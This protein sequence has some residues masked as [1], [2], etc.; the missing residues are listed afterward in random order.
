MGRGFPYNSQDSSLAI[1]GNPGFTA[2]DIPA[3]ANLPTAKWWGAEGPEIVAVKRGRLLVQPGGPGDPMQVL[4][5]S[6]QEA[7]P[8]GGGR[9]T[10]GA[11]SVSPREDGSFMV[12][13]MMRERLEVFDPATKES[14]PQFVFRYGT[15]A[16]FENLN[17][18][19]FCNDE[20]FALDANKR[21]VHVDLATGDRSLVHEFEDA[22]LLEFIAAD[23]DGRLVVVDHEF[24][25][26][27][28]VVIDPR[29]PNATP[30]AGAYFTS[31]RNII[32]MSDR[33][34]P[35]AVFPNISLNS[36]G[37][38][39]EAGFSSGPLSNLPLEN[40]VATQSGYRA[41]VQVPANHE[42]TAQVAVIAMGP[43]DLYY[44]SSATFTAPD[45]TVLRMDWPSLMR[46]ESPKGTTGKFF[47][48]HTEERAAVAGEWDVELTFHNG[49][50]PTELTSATL[51]L[52]PLNSPT[53]L[54]EG[55]TTGVITLLTNHPPQ[56]HLLNTAT[57]QTIQIS[58][59]MDGSQPDYLNYIN[60]I[61]Y[62]ADGQLLAA[63]SDRVDLLSVD[64]TTGAATS[65]GFHRPQEHE[66]VFGTG[67]FSHLR[68]A[69]GPD[70]RVRRPGWA[71]FGF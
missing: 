63:P 40:I 64:T 15:G 41:T 5:D 4:H 45:D 18:L 46:A 9:D 69:A 71:Y 57:N 55:P 7:G 43:M 8:R 2:D 25:N 58:L 67:E 17:D 31:S 32:A 20:L 47:A 42:G 50:K 10:S 56:L 62:T 30:S 1:L 66:E 26:L 34:D 68:L 53:A 61:A 38:I 6:F 48:V 24:G 19:V 37:R 36:F 21:I 27:R 52:R 29:V 54:A 49:S 51:S 23:N 39:T 70:P 65:L 60:E 59:T 11:I 35:Y 28:K 16:P 3:L 12:Y 14:E 22:S 13:D 33:G 44:L